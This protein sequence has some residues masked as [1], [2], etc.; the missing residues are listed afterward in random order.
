M[1][2]L[3]QGSGP[4]PA[5]PRPRSASRAG[6]TCLSRRSVQWTDWQTPTEDDF[7]SLI[8]GWQGDSPLAWLHKNVGL[9]A[10]RT[11]TPQNDKDRLSGDMWYRDSFRAGD[12][13]ALRLSHQSQR[14]RPARPARLVSAR[15]HAHGPCD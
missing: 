1:H 3:Q 5:R 6:R 15:V 7:K 4:A 9:H 2:H 11:M 13:R 10:P 14:A 8:D 12:L